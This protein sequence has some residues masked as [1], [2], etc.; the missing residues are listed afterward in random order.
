MGKFTFLV[1]ENA[2]DVCEGIIR[3]MQP[4][5]K[6]QSLGYC[7]GVK[8]AVEKIASNKPHLLYLD[9][10]LNGGSAFEILQQIQNLPSYNPYIIF[11]TGFQKDNPEIPQEIIN[12]YSV[13][14]YLVKPLWENLRNNLSQYLQE[15]EEKCIQFFKKESLVWIEDDNKSK[16]LVDLAKIICICQHPTEPRCRNIYLLAKEK[17]IT[18][19]LQ[20]Q[21]LYDL[22]TQN[23]IEF[24]ITKNRSHLVIKNFVEKFEKPFV[25]LR[26]LTAF[27]IDVVKESTKDFEQWLLN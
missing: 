17:E 24:F 26:G 11:N 21:K 12:T 19:P 27:K 25:R 18:I 20:W 9:W 4:Y 2:P 15:A 23:E 3:R 10:S 14:K 16:V 1:V 7:V 13:D 22:L 5:T 6:W 8:E